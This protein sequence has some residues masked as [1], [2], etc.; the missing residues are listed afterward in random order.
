M[1]KNYLK[2]AF[3][4]LKTAKAFS[5]IN[6]TGLAVGM[7]SA[8]LILLWI[9]NE[10]SHDRFH[11]KI[12]RIYTTNNRDKFNGQLYA[13]SSQPR[14]MAPTLKKDFP[15]VED[16]VRVN[17]TTFLLSVGEKHLNVHGNFTDPGFLSMFSFPLLKGNAGTALNG[18]YNIVIT[19]KLA[20]KLFGNDDPM[21]RIIRI[22]SADNFT[23][24]GIMKDLPNNTVFDFEY[25]LPW[26]YQKKIGYD[27]DEWGNNAVFDYVLLKPGV[28]A[29]NFD[30][31][32]KNITIDHT[33]NGEKATT[34][35][36]TQPLKDAWLYSRSE[37]GKFVAG[38][39]VTVRLFALI[40]AFILIIACINFMNLST[41]R[42]EKRAKEVGI[43]KV[44][45]AQK[46]WLIGQFIGE[47]ILLSAI[48]G[49]LSVFIVELCLPSFNQLVSK[50]LSINFGAI[51]FWAF[52]L[53][54]ILIT[55]IIA[56]SYPAFYL[57]SFLPVKVLKGTFKSSHSLVTPRKILVIVQFTFAITLI[58][59]TLIIEH[60]INYAENRDLGYDKNRL[61][62]TWLQG[63]VS[64]HYESI[65]DELLN[66]GAAVA[67]TKSMSPITQRYSDGWGWSWDGSTQADDKTDF[68]RMASDMDFAKTMGVKIV[69]GRDINIKEY[70]SDSTAMLLN[71][72]AV[73]VMHIKNP[74]GLT[75]REGGQ[76]WHVVGVLKDFIYESPYQKVQQLAVL[77]P[78]TWFTT[79]HL[80]LNP[81]HEV[82]E[83]LKKAEAIF[84]KYN[85]QYPFEY[86]F[87]DDEYGKKFN[88]S[89][90]TGT[91]AALF[92]GL[93]I[94]IS[95]LG[96]FGLAA[97]M[98]EA[99]IK[100]IG[101]RK[102]LGA[103]VANIIT[104]LSRDFVTLVII[105]I[106]I[107][108]PIALFFMSKWLQ[109]YDYRISIGW[110]VFAAAGGFA[111]AIALLT[112]S[113]QAA[114]AALANPAKNLRTE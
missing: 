31:K 77:G 90:R 112:V 14:I 69:E 109:D 87:A 95:C 5:I 106:V 45:G 13:W 53:G 91:L 47:S 108:S 60:Q 40:A 24:T 10:I 86:H 81:A 113:F 27:D 58:I 56:G 110:V 22:D 103:S 46:S 78:K 9:Q 107:A 76:V 17:E 79:M 101:V 68:V 35:V 39:M 48:A 6:I 11:E 75:V 26:L 88:E 98:A 99:R 54:F 2:I 80:K 50:E 25:L 3:R 84:K 52:F 83:N 16:A 57:S 63:G 19:E 7:A 94:F 111:V 42:S 72:T 29:S 70:P 62:F 23:V 43:R 36:F 38:R 64:A 51:E 30:A 37:N 4:H 100:E 41:A 15:E 104:L 12:D 82:S 61:V 33:K 74:I 59:C 114:R 73:K 34:Q 28:R 21:G 105:S 18:M 85:P 89:R 1:L 20:K 8:I 67:V 66:S 93:T 44:V 55:G 65:K 102:V 32:I 49:V 96:L 92:A 97:Y 71:E